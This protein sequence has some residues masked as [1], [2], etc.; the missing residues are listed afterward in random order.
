MSL[1]DEPLSEYL[2]SIDVLVTDVSSVATDF[3]YT[4]RPV[5]V[6]NTTSEPADAFVELFPSQRGCYLVDAAGGNLAGLLEDALG[7]DSLR[8]ER[9][10]TMRRLHGDVPEG[11]VQRFVDQTRRLAAAAQAGGSQ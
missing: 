1:P 7:P 3:L 11:V 10:V 5:L 9:L 8:T 4:R 6:V 2:N